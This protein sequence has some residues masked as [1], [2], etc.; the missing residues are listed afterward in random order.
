MS[1]E[2]NVMPFAGR[3]R[4]RPDRRRVAEFAATARKLQEERAAAEDVVTRVLAERPRAEWPSLP[5]LRNVGAVERLGREIERRLDR[6]PRE[7]LAIAETATEIADALDTQM[8]PPV[9]VAQ[10]RA[11]AWK[12]RAQALCY[13]ARFEE[14]LEA[15][16]KADVMLETFGTLAHDLAIVRFVRATTMGEQSRFDESIQLLHECRGVFN[17]H[18]DVR[19]ELL[20]G[21]AQGSLLHRMK[22]FRE[23]RDA[24]LPLLEVAR[25]LHDSTSEAY[26]HHNIGYTSADLLDFTAAASH[27][28]A[29]VEIFERLDQPLNAAR[30]EIVRGVMFAR[31]GENRRA[32]T[33]IHPIRTTFLANGL[34]EEAGVFGLEIVQ[35]R[36]ALGE[37]R[38]AEMLARQIILE[39]KAASLN[40]RAI[41][42][43]GYLTEAISRRT[44]SVATVGGV[45]EYIVSLR[46]HPEREFVAC[47]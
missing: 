36:L 45:R 19:R 47:A 31:R 10:K 1:E 6:D 3:A 38:E 46:R 28:D 25:E 9:M 23:A 22:R 4:R 13:L 2:S 43:L 8:Y 12:D 39:F 27:L 20:C 16:D 26:L 17:S 18:G 42:A 32:I 44:A 33:H 21:I 41:S 35:A 37:A 30:T 29:A 15:L 5:E 14:A 24:Y 34:V 11:H 40:A 7:A